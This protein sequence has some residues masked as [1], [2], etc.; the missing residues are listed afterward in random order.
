MPVQG[1][2]AGKKLII[3]SVNGFNPRART[4]HDAGPKSSMAFPIGFNPRARTGHD[5]PKTERRGDH[6]TVSIHVPV[7]GT[8]ALTTAL[9]P[10][11]WFQSTC[12]YRARL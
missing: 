4:G 11:E 1:T 3:D 12:P 7:Q 10:W 8:T 2:T 6:F 5:G 9:K